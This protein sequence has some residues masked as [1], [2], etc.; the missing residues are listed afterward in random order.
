MIGQ[1]LWS[2]TINNILSTQNIIQATC[3]NN[4]RTINILAHPVN[5]P[6]LIFPP[7]Q[8]SPLVHHDQV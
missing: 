4:N 5:A 1:G 7:I 3:I 8:L 6:M 2:S